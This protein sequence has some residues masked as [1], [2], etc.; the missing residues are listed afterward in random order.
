MSGFGTL[1]KQYLEIYKIS[2]VDFAQRLGIT[3]KHMNEILNETT[4][5]SVDLMIAI[6]LLTDIE[7]NYIMK[8]ESKK[9]MYNYLINKFQNEKEIKNY[10]E[11]FKIKQIYK[12]GWIELEDKT[13]YV[14]NAI[15]L[16]EYINLRTFDQFEEYFD[17]KIISQKEIK[18]K[19]STF[20]WIKRCDNLA[21]RQEVK[22]YNSKNLI[23][24]LKEIKEKENN[25][26]I[27]EITKLLN[28]YGIY[29]VLEESL[30]KNIRACSHVKG[31]NPAIYINKNIND[32]A[33]FYYSLYYELSKVKSYF[34]KLKK[35]IILSQ[36]N[37]KIQ[38]QH[39][40]ALN[41]MVPKE[42]YQKIK[43]SIYNID[44]ICKKNKVTLEFAH[45]RLKKDNLIKADKQY[46]KIIE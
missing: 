32:K 12:L 44:T 5:I 10:L 4:E 8:V 30:D 31:T 16:L 3:Q 33:E 38:K 6:S 14:T 20:V 19:K 26:T 37:E 35:I 7:P 24:L 2:Q 34:N 41:E 15:N 17:N 25:N 42:K 21:K 40:F 11:T 29:L 46:Q 39:Q 45:F 43:V 18:D 13:S 23:I 1:L 22:T 27:K 28:D 36:K 9:R